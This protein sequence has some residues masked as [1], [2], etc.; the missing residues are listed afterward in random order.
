MPNALF[1]LDCASPPKAPPDAGGAVT[2]LP[3]AF[4]AEVLL[5][6]D[7]G[8][9][10]ED[11]LDHTGF[12]SEPAGFWAAVAKDVGAADANAANPPPELA[13]LPL[14][15]AGLAAAPKDDWPNAGCTKEHWPKGD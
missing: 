8:S 2:V 1:W 3:K 5:S 14:G 10:W 13:V 7:F 11:E 4:T 15:V 6:T 12:A 9:C